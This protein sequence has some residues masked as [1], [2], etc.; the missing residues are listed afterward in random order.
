[1]QIV[2]CKLGHDSNVYDCKAPVVDL[3]ILPAAPNCLPKLHLTFPFSYL[4]GL[5][6][7]PEPPR[8]FSVGGSI[9]SAGVG[10][11]CPTVSGSRVRTLSTAKVTPSH[12]TSASVP[13]PAQQMHFAI[14][15]KEPGSARP[16][17]PGSYVREPSTAKTP[18]HLR[19]AF[20]PFPAQ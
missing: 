4:Q 14:Q 7:G 10:S 11:A 8:G 19:S 17:L 3:A 1:M 12:L 13:L 18:G 16:T 6:H 20:V 5:W 9:G 2:D 15:A